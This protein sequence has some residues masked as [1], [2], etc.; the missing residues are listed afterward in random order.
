MHE[1]S[2]PLW[3]CVYAPGLE[4][5]S[6]EWLP[7]LFIILSLFVLIYMLSWRHNRTQKCGKCRLNQREKVESEFMREQFN[8]FDTMSM[9]YMKCKVVKDASG[10]SVDLIY[11]EINILLEKELSAQGNVLNRK[12]TEVAGFIV[13]DFLI[14]IDKL[15][16]DRVSCKYPYYSPENGRFYDIYIHPSSTPDVIYLYCLDNTHVY[17]VTQTL[18]STNYK[19]SIAMDEGGFVTWG[20]EI[21]NKIV[22]YDVIREKTDEAGNTEK[23][24]ERMYLP[25]LQCFQQIAERDRKRVRQKL[26]MLQ[27]GTI[28]KVKIEYC[29]I[30]KTKQKQAAWM[31]M[32][33]AVEQTDEE[34]RPTVLSGTILDISKWKNIEKELERSKVEKEESIR[35]KRAFLA[36]I[37]HEIRTPLNAIVGFSTILTQI[38]NEEER[39]EY[40]NIVESNNTLLLQLINDILDFSDIEADAIDL[41]RNDF[42]LNGLMEEFEFNLKAKLSSRNIEAVFEKKEVLNLYINSDL[43]RLR[44]VLFNLLKNAVKFTSEGTI[45]FGYELRNRVIYFYVKDTG[46]G[47]AKENQKKIF[48]HFVKLDSF[49]QGTGLGLSICKAIVEKM[50]GKIGVKSEVGKGSLFWFT[51]PYEPVGLI[52]EK[53]LRGV[54]VVPKDQLIVIVADEDL[55]NFQ[56]IRSMLPDKFFLIHALSG[57][58]ML[59]AFNE[60]GAGLILMDIAMAE[61]DKFE[62]LHGIRKMS[63]TVPVIAMTESV[64]SPQQESHILAS[65]FSSCISRPINRKSLLDR[66]CLAYNLLIPSDSTV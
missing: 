54:L 39:Q 11:L 34:G 18:H 12:M 60:T 48:E 59:N 6:L 10:K 61:K 29:T 2:F 51:I 1:I 15:L 42:D 25:E 7:A 41:N 14:A 44:Q 3:A 27:N 32:H 64:V 33:A 49:T 30:F 38:K 65:G 47:I 56:R 9:L 8:L 45:S 26:Q 36:N 19:L 66:I 57:T 35:L 55:S 52:Q 4:S 23:V 46:C 17:E 62:S 43:T 20:W 50:G 31:E 28:D 5:R 40:V 58:E 37:N 24:V 16:Q 22:Y 13:P 21:L 63:P 53:E